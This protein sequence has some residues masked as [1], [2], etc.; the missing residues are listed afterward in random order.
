MSMV[1]RVVVGK[2]IANFAELEIGGSSGVDGFV[3][4]TPETLDENSNCS[5][6]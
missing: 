3:A 5:Q 1:C 6:N 2:I 4:S